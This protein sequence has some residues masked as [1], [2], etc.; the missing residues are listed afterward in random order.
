[1][2]RRLKEFGKGVKDKEG[3]KFMPNTVQIS[4]VT[5]LPGK[6]LEEPY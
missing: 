6:R 3:V 5:P 4:R 1:M 2:Q